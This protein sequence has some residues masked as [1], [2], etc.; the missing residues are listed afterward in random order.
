MNRYLVLSL[1]A[2]F[3]HLQI[4]ADYDCKVSL[5]RGESFSTLL[6]DEASHV[7]GSA[8]GI[9]VE[10]GTLMPVRYLD[11]HKG[12]E[13]RTVADRA[14][15]GS[16]SAGVHFATVTASPDAKPGEYR[17]GQ[18]VVRVVDRVLPPA[19]EWIPVGTDL[20]KAL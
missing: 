11:D 8:S 2:A 7:E 6:P 20:A 19:Q 16:K 9:S 18:L 14:E 10:R 1:F 17:F 12:L 13:Y 4:K 3:S 15:A 5:W